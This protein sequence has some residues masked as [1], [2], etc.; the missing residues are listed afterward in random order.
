V[1]AL[2]RVEACSC[3]GRF[4][5][6]RAPITGYN[7][8]GHHHRVRAPHPVSST[9]QV[10]RHVT[11][12]GTS[13][14]TSQRRE[15]T[16]TL[17]PRRTVGDRRPRCGTSLSVSTTASG[18]SIPNAWSGGSRWALHHVDVAAVSNSSACPSRLGMTRPSVPRYT[19]LSGWQPIGVPSV[20][21]RPRYGHEWA[22]TQPHEVFVRVRTP[23]VQHQL[24]RQRWSGWQTWWRHQPEPEG[25]HDSTDSGSSPSGGNATVSALHGQHRYLVRVGSLGGAL[26]SDPVVTDAT[27]ISVFASAGQRG[28]TQRYTTAPETG[29]VELRRVRQFADRC[30]KRTRPDVALRARAGNAIWYHTHRPPISRLL[31]LSRWCIN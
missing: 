23:S 7:I 8:C 18:T 2:L 25:R 19:G 10:H 29:Q 20:R 30:D 5:P 22:R 14:S 16:G 13:T 21:T 11:G 1:T 26:S 28:L 27:G 12:D 15:R 3:R 17:R 9:T 4:P 6:R 24:K 31:A